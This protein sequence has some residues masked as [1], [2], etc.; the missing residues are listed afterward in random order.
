MLTDSQLKRAWARFQAVCAGKVEAESFYPA[1]QS[2]YAAQTQSIL[3]A[4]DDVFRTRAHQELLWSARDITPVG[5][6]DG[7]SVE[8]LLTDDTFAER[9]ASLRRRAWPAD[10]DARA[11]QIQA[12]HDELAE[13]VRSAVSK[14]MP[15][16]RLKRAFAALLPRELTCVIAYKP[17]LKTA[18]LLLDG[19]AGGHLSLQARQRARL[20]EALGPERT[21]EDDVRRA[22][23][24]WWL[25]VHG[26]EFRTKNAASGERVSSAPD[27]TE[28]LAVWPGTKQFTSIPWFG[29]LSRTVRWVTQQT[30]DGIPRED[31]IDA[32][33]GLENRNLSPKSA[34]SVIRRTK[35][36]GLLV[37]RD[38]QLW[39]SDAGKELL[40]DEQNDVLVRNLIERFFGFAHALRHLSTHQ[41]GV[42]AVD[43]RTALQKLYPPW[44]SSFPPDHVRKWLTDLGLVEKEKQCVSI[45]A[46][47]EGWAALLPD[48][49]PTPP[50]ASVDD[51][52]EADELETEPEAAPATV[53]RFP[54]FP[55]IQR[56]F[57]ADEQARQLVLDPVQMRSLHV[58][59]QCQP[60]KRFVILA[61]LSGTGKTALAIHYARAVCALASLDLKR[62]LAVVPVSP[63]W[64]DPSGLLGY[65]N[66][67][68][69]DPT[70]H[71]EP[72]LR[73]LLRASRDPGAPYFLVLDEMNL[74]RVE[75][76]FAPM[77]SA[78][79]TKGEFVV[80]A[81]P[82]VVNG[83]PPKILWPR[84]LYIAGTVNMD[85]T[86]HSFSDKVIDRAFTL[87]FWEVDLA[88]FFERRAG[89]RYARVEQLLLTLYA[90]LRP[91][92][93]HFGYRTAREVLEFVEALDET[94]S[95]RVA[96]PFL[97][98][99]IFSRVLPR[100]RGDESPELFEALNKL[101][102][103]CKA[104]ELSR[105]VAKLRD[106]HARLKRSGVTKFFS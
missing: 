65:F 45:T 42:D 103:S 72:A 49:L 71:A 13:A 38:Q 41:D 24:C 94:G 5:P 21:L 99:V 37:E 105:C 31:L 84:N 106:M 9:F 100:I 28:P 96:S 54:D 23:F 87:E 73:L 101:T 80:H 20:R 3:A 57:A 59:W 79:E 26:D 81:N 30:I 58:A 63:D 1:W 48:K 55:A 76:Y 85:E 70:F 34:R 27:K 104:N 44:G 68:H 10:A 66:A 39:P 56:W 32:L 90:H 16:A 18:A 64:R 77:L 22:T 93:R 75:R 50:V 36:I 51:E 14:R 25:S 4:S 7:V 53:V 88:A 19:E 61:G 78:M 62:H 69:A 91:I 6:G 83:V 98:Q 60:A 15:A 17:N 86:T 33:V 29:G 52:S 74:A 47:G 40:E 102:A 82:D 2:R 92:R 12:A 8:E 11:K 35:R 67:L 95:G 43:L 89:R 46:Y 97:D